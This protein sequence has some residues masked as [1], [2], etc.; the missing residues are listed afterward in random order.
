MAKKSIVP[1]LLLGGAALLM[2][3]KSGGSAKSSATGEGLIT[4]G[5][6]PDG[7]TVVFIDYA[8]AC[9]SDS[10][11]IS[12]LG[13]SDIRAPGDFA[14]DVVAIW[15]VATSGGEDSVAELV[16]GA[17]ASTPAEMD[18]LVFAMINLPA[19]D[20][21][22]TVYEGSVDG[23]PS[24]SQ[25]GPGAVISNSVEQIGKGLTGHGLGISWAK[26]ASDIAQQLA[27]EY[28]SSGGDERR[29]AI[30]IGEFFQG[31]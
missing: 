17:R 10:A 21:T 9:I 20:E 19:E 12:I 11:C 18:L 24:Y 3:G 28:A 4:V 1:I 13:S 25:E 30:E 31:E 23:E 5:R 6:R 8:N 22:I 27:S 7:T 15:A 16:D 29:A 14:S 26:D 2:M